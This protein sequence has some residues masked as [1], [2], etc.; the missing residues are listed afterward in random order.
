MN[1]FAGRISAC[2]RHPNVGR[3]PSIYGEK[4]AFGQG[5]SPIQAKNSPLRQKLQEPI[6]SAPGDNAVFG[7]SL[8]ACR[9]PGTF[10]EPTVQNQPVPVLYDR[11]APPSNVQAACSP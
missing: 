7:L 3:A 8:T 1:S 4:A 9:R 2:A 11:W 5:L 10:V 6:G